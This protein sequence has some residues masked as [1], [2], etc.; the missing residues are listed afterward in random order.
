MENLTPYI[1]RSRRLGCD[2]P[3]LQSLVEYYK[4]KWQ[5]TYHGGQWYDRHED[6][7]KWAEVLDAG[8]HLSSDFSID[9]VSYGGLYERLS[10]VASSEE[11]IGGMVSDRYAWVIDF[12]AFVSAFLSVQPVSKILDLGCSYGYILSSLN[13]QHDFEGVGIDFSNGA[14]TFAQSFADR[15]SLSLRYVQSTYQDFSLKPSELADLVIISHPIA[16]SGLDQCIE[17]HLAPGGFLI[18]LPHL[19]SSIPSSSDLRFLW[20]EVCG[21]YIEHSFQ[22]GCIYVFQRSPSL[23]SRRVTVPRTWIGFA[24]YANEGSRDKAELTVAHYLSTEEARKNN[25]CVYMPLVKM[26]ERM[27]DES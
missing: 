2:Q 12:T 27:R 22:S 15:D 25:R 24:E 9:E 18:Y 26:L 8:Y 6:D 23:K 19:I 7:P 14:V 4:D 5:I 16:S 11:F 17:R 3:T 1:N 20:S 21:G 13:Q 10:D